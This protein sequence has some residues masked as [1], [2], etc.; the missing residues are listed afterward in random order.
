MGYSKAEV[1]EASTRYFAESPLF[2]P[3]MGPDDYALPATVFANKYALQDAAGVFHE[4]TPD[5]MHRRLARAFAR[6]EARYVNPM[7]EEEIF[8]LLRHFGM[9]V[10]QGS[11]MAGI[12]NPFQ[13]VSTSN[14]AVRRAPEDT[15]SDIFDVG[16][17]MANLYKARFG[18]GTDLSKLRP[19]GAPV[20]NSARTSTGAWSFADFYSNITRMVGQNGRRGALMLTLDVRH[21]DVEAFIAMKADLTKVTG[22]NV[23]VKVTDAF[24]RAVEADAAF[25]LQ[26][27]VDVPLAE[28]TVTREVRA[29]EVFALIAR[30]A[31]QNAEPGLLFWDRITVTQPLAYYTGFALVST[32]PCGEIPLPDGDSCRLISLYLPAFVRDKFTRHAWFDTEAFAEVVRKA[33]RLSDDLVDLELDALAAL[34]AQ[35]DTEDA[36][37]LYA[38]FIAKC[39]LGRRTGL[40]THGL[41]DALAQLRVRYDA[42]EA[43]AAAAQIYATLRN[44]A[45]ASSVE[46]AEERGPF[47]LYHAEIE[48]DCPFLHELPLALRTRMREVGRRNGALLTNAPTGTTSLCSGNSSSGIEPVFANVQIRNTKVDVARGAGT[49]D[50]VDAMGDAWKRYRLYHPNV[51]RFLRTAHA[52]PTLL[53]VARPDDY[54]GLDF[55]TFAERA[56]LPAF[57]VTAGEIAWE[58]RVRMQG[59]IQRY[60][61]HSISSTL[62]LPRETTPETVEAI[63][64]AAWHHGLKGV[65]V[66][67]DGSREAQVLTDAAAGA[68][69]TIVDTTATVP[70]AAAA[71]IA[72]LTDLV[73]GYKQLLADEMAKD[74]DCIKQ[75]TRGAATEGAMRKATFHDVDGRERKVYA[76]VG[77]N[78]EGAPVEAFV[79][80]EQGDE[81]LKPYAAAMAKLVSLALKRGV[82]PAEVADTIT[83][84]RGGSISYGEKTYQSVP[85]FVGRL[86][87][88]AIPA[89]PGVGVPAPLAPGEPEGP[90]RAITGAATR[91]VVDVPK[92]FMKCPSC[93]GWNVRKVDG[94]PLCSDCGWGRC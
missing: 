45:Y 76:Y 60:I 72:R 81:E 40:G 17:D 65:T 27:P 74:A 70:S 25:T 9:V 88:A 46:M 68:P 86:L 84:L 48:A 6:V 37:A 69:E 4:R 91:P 23:S 14:C 42:P 34:H 26:W 75:T 31:N 11:P 18:V 62:N 50:F 79:I 87:T 15:M 94:C 80:D 28:A 16:R 56:P 2:V 3:G 82:P 73:A 54:R 47:P 93:S 13:V 44:A 10:P 52:N 59:T 57:F 85:D 39:R 1:V 21:P 63:Y 71:E 12:D 55:E 32:N 8:G 24:M 38:T 78:A 30:M 51:L 35:A 66:Y 92:G 67:R 7:P 83:G 20:N 61:D 89:A 43:E 77:R 22:A 58:S 5:D 49:Y 64:R 19:A 53:D 29:R 41:A 33:Q 36:R 90:Y